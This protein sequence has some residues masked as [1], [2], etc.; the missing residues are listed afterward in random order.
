MIETQAIKFVMYLYG[1]LQLNKEILL[2]KCGIPAVYDVRN[3]V[4]D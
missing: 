3:A 1:I 4:K 2:V